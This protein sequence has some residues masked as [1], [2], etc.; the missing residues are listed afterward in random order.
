MWGLHQEWTSKYYTN[1]SLK[2]LFEKPA[3]SGSL[4]LNPLPSPSDMLF[5]CYLLLLTGM[6]LSIT[7]CFL[8]KEVGSII[9]PFSWGKER[10]SAICGLHGNLLYTCVTSQTP[11][12]GQY[13]EN[14]KSRNDGSAPSSPIPKSA[15]E[16][17]ARLSL[18]L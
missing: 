4:S 7:S 3:L 17:S 2:S 14:K 11:F 5:P 16:G 1:L 13:R 8:M 9:S 12:R 15:N 18:R 10:E 6:V